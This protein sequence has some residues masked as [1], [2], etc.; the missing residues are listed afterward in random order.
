MSHELPVVVMSHE[1]PVVVM[2]HEP[3]EMAKSVQLHRTVLAMAHMLLV[4]CM[5]ARC[6]CM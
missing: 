6:M 1:L 2:S 4:Y 3:P 5:Y